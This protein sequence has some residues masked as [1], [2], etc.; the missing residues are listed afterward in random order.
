[1]CK[2][3]IEKTVSCSGIGVH[4]G[5]E[6]TVVIKPAPPD[7]G[8]VFVR[9]DLDPPLRIVATYENIKSGI[10]ATTI[11]EGG[12][13]VS[14]IEHLMAALSAL[15]I[16]S[17]E[18][19]V[20]GP[21][22]PIMDGSA[23]PFVSLIKSA[24]IRKLDCSRRYLVVEKPV[25]V[26]IN[27]SRASIRPSLVPSVNCSIAYDHPYLRYQQRAVRINPADFESEIA[28]ARTYGFLEDVNRLRSMGLA[29]GGSLEN[30]L[31]LDSKGVVNEEGMRYQDECVRHKILDV[32]GDMALT[33]MPVL[34]EVYCHKSGHRLSH[35]LIT[36]LM[37]NPDSYRIVDESELDAP[38]PLEEKTLAQASSWV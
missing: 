8:T 32:I 24:G 5:E 1:M 12:V 13:S 30:A 18:I 6:A 29:K 26:N 36:E 20:N 22:L 34:G 28:A 14:T 37:K 2:R 27:G 10:N 19:E 7:H 4:A 31:V 35:K 33:G 25:Q 21:E 15:M 3:T 9:T 38:G 23:A 17:V 11:G 16:D